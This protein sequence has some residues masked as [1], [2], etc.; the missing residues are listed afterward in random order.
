MNKYLI[1]ALC[2]SVCSPG[3]IAQNS[4]SY[5]TLP[6]EANISGKLY[7][8]AMSSQ[9]SY[10]LHDQWL[11]GDV[12]LATGK[13]VRNVYLK[14][15]T[16]IDELIWL[17]VE[18][19][20]AVQADKKLTEAFVISLPDREDGMVFQNISVDVAFASGPVNMFVNVLYEGSISLMVHRRVIKKRERLISADG[21]YYPVPV[22]E[23]DPVYYI[24]LSDG[25][26][27]EPGRFTRR[28]LYGV[29]PGYRDEIRSAFR[30]DRLLRIRTEDD[31]IHAVS[32]IDSI[33]D[34]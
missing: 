16:Y 11:K 13:V 21:G 15:N 25:E 5:V 28:A 20:E 32:L 1:I 22:L 23:P 30:R 26:V 14:Y 12:Y 4:R 24:V 34:N 2:L 17:P 19:Y 9:G 6:Y 3:V 10:Y 29:F 33:I 7:T 8:F 27:F 31:M 18:S